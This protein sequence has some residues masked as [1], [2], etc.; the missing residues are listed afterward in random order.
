MDRADNLFQTIEMLRPTA[1]GGLARQA[2]ARHVLPVAPIYDLSAIPRRDGPDKAP[3]PVAQVKPGHAT[4]GDAGAV[5]VPVAGRS[6]PDDVITTKTALA[7]RKAKPLPA[8]RKKSSAD[9]F[10]DRLSR[11][12]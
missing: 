3:V 8:K 11:L 12:G 7:L 6:L 4:L 9:Q 2:S 10:A 5:A 1:N